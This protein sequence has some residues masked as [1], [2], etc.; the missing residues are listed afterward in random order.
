V[1]GADGD[2]LRTPLA[3]PPPVT[4]MPEGPRLSTTLPGRA[5]APALP[6]PRIG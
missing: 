4:V 1:A 2:W 3:V 6:P 5:V